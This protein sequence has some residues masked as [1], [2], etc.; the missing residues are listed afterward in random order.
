MTFV[1]TIQD[2]LTNQTYYI[3]EYMGIEICLDK[4][5]YKIMV[6]NDPEVIEICLN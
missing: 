6:D 4:I 5:N 2:E 1:Y 3:M